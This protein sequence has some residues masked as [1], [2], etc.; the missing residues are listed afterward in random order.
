MGTTLVMAVFQPTRLVVAH[1]GDSRCYRLREHVLEP[2]TKDH[3]LLPAGLD[4]GLLTPQQAAISGNRNLV[5]RALGIED[6]VA[7]R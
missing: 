1:L 5:T 3:S 6:M 2:L 4:A 7:P